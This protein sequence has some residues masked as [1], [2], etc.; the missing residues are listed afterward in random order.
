MLAERLSADPAHR[1]LVLEAGGADHHPLVSMPKGIAKLV[2]RADFTWTF[3]IRQPRRPNM[4]AS[5]VWIRGKSLGGSSSINGMI[6]SRGHPEDY[7]EWNTLGGP[8]WGWQEMKAVYRRIECHELG[9]ADHRGGAGPL[10]VQTG[11]FR[12]PIADELIRAG[13]EF[14]LPSKEDMNDETLEGIGYYNHNIRN[15]Q[16]MSASRVFL[17]PAMKRDNLTVVMNAHVRRV[18]IDQGFAVGVECDVAGRLETFECRGEVILC[19]GT[20]LSPKI[21]QLSGVGPAAALEQAGV[22]LVRDSPDVGRRMREHLGFSM[23]HRLK[24]GR[25]INH[26]LRRFGLLA[27]VLR[28]YLTRGGPLATGPFEVGAFVRAMPGANR[29]DTQLYMGAFS[30]ARTEGSRPV[31]LSTPDKEPGITIYGQLLNLTSEGEVMI[32]SADPDLPPVITPNWLQTEYDQKAMIQM[33]KTMRRF[34]RETSASRYFGEELL[35]GSDCKTDDEIL[36]AV[37]LGATSGLHGTGTCR[38]GR[39]QDSVVDHQLKVRGVKG[40]RVADCSIMPT[41]VSGNTN[42]PA[43]AVGWRASDLIL[44]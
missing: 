23:P 10:P 31:Q 5:E 18:F 37:L 9:E 4:P 11:Q 26:R 44:S 17:R 8:G 32:E 2:R 13:E 29:P 3:P 41:L 22:P 34:V 30:Y 39:D 40:L 6:Y 35:P 28:Y 27:S 43:M 1:V 36:S 42:A 33:V 19:A 20:I 12:Y 14:G 7:E 16:R 15:G 24:N 21:L 38:M 25:G